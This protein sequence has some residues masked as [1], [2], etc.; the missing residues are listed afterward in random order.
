MSSNKII[1]IVKQLFPRPSLWDYIMGIAV[2]FAYMAH[3]LIGQLDLEIIKPYRCIF[4]GIL[5][6]FPLA[7]FRRHIQPSPRSLKVLAGC[8]GFLFSQFVSIGES[9]YLRNN[10]SFC[11]E[12]WPAIVI[13]A[14]QALC[15]GYV[16]YIIVLGFLSILQCLHPDKDLYK[17]DLRKWFFIIL[18][19]KLVFFV[20]LFPC[21]FDI[22]ASIGLRTFLDSNSA[23][24][25]HHP[26]L[27]QS[28]HGL[29]YLF[30]QSLGS[31]SLGFAL[32]SFIFIFVSCCI[33]IYGLSLFEQANIGKK[34]ITAGALIFAFFPLF[35]YL[36]L[37]ITKDGLF[38]YFFL[39]YIF[40]IYELYISKGNCLKKSR[41]LALHFTSVLLM[42]LTRH[43]GFYLVVLEFILLLFC[44]RSHWKRISATTFSALILFLGYSKIILP[45]LNVEPSGKQEMY[46]TLFHQTAHY[47]NEYPN[48]VTES[49]QNAI[50][51]ILDKNSI[52]QL[53]RYDLTDGSKDCYKYNPMISPTTG[54]PVYFRHVNHSNEAQELEAYRTAWLSMFQRHP[55]SYI[56]ATL[57]VCI[58]FFSTTMTRSSK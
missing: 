24:C 31:P 13:W 47:L 20:A 56:Q 51:A 25:N 32:L 12:S 40:T 57:G 8:I 46:S 45:S 14:F 36:N 22:D 2:I 37:L 41:F 30:G 53:Y 3:F 27:V 52:S 18:V 50:F 9:F 21:V 16:F 26:F 6:P 54:Y 55:L 29:F 43:Q 7:F 34:C 42:C 39:L 38:A 17:V 58:G 1:S 15:Y 33:L 5:T 19:V 4:Y 10:L 28:L 48:D 11:F 23:I 44:Y 49:E 35:P